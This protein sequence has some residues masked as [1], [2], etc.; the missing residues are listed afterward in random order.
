VLQNAGGIASIHYSQQACQEEKPQC[1]FKTRFVL[2]VDKHN[3]AVQFRG[4]TA[5]IRIVTAK[6]PKI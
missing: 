3:E 5:G 1:T 2:F 6:N 4:R